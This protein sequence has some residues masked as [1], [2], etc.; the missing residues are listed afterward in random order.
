MKGSF[1]FF[2]TVASVA[3]FCYLNIATAAPPP[4]APT[5]GAVQSTLPTKPVKP[6]PAPAP[7]VQ[8]TPAPAPGVSAGGPAV[9]VKSFEI[10]GNTVFS[11]AELQAQIAAWVGKRQTLAQLYDVADKLTSFYRQHGYGLAYVSLPAQTLKDGSVRL[12]VVEGRIGNIAIQGNDNTGSD[13]LINRVSNIHTG[14]IYTDAG[15]ERA[16]TLLNDL[17]GVHARA[18]LSPGQQFG[19]SDVLFKVQETRYNGDASID[20]YGRS[21]IGR[22]R[23]NADVSVNSLTG[24]GDQLSAGITHSAGNLLN[25][26]K[27]GYS[28]PLGPPGGTLTAGWNRAVYHVGGSLFGPLDIS[29]VT[30]NGSLNYLYEQERTRSESFYWGFG[31]SHNTSDVDTS[32]KRIVTTNIN[33]LQLTTFYIHSNPD[34]SYY[35]L[36]GNL[37]TNGKRNDGTKNSAERLRLQFDA[38]DVQPFAT[39]WR[40]I[41]SAS[42]LYSPDPLV[43]TDKFSLG[44]PDNVRGFLPAEQRGDRG[45]FVSLELQR[46]FAIGGLPMALGGFVDSGKVWNVATSALPGNNQGLTSAGAEWLFGPSTGVWSA[47]LQWAYAVGG[48]RP[49]DGNGGGHIWFT[50]GTKF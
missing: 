44:G 18:V 46:S 8:T 20:D 21:V 42:V 2:A 45:A 7:A 15:M 23:V 1:A 31:T 4:S 13:T 14:D 37:W 32:G 40:F 48:Y 29:G 10:T 19:T 35:T 41:T 30:Q 33:L 38:S 28:L 49:S 27:L 47:R 39:L 12:Q 24:H 34:F 50:L 6:K 25:F 43:D 22:W 3:A 17:P 9:L 5:P 26:G 16:A 11:D 36:A